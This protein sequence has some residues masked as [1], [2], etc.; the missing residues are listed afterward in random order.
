MADCPDP[1][2]VAR[3]GHERR[4]HFAHRHAETK[5][6]SKEVFLRET[7]EMIAQW[8][9]GFT[10]MNL[11]LRV[12]GATAE[13][14][15]T[16]QKSGKQLH[17][18]L[19]YDPSY[20]PGFNQL[21]SN[22]RQFLLGHT[23]GLLLPR[24]PHKSI[25]GAWWCASPRLVSTLVTYTGHALA[26]NPQEQLV[27]T[28]VNASYARR[29]GV[30]ASSRTIAENICLVEPFST[31]K[32]TEDGIV[33]PALERFLSA[34]HLEEQRW[35][36]TSTP[37]SPTSASSSTGKPRDALQAEYMRRAAGMTTEERLQLLREMFVL[38]APENARKD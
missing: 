5:H 8:I 4:H 9:G 13:L 11:E 6:V 34:R 15:I 31:C 17:L 33:A 25:D 32:L 7:T 30:I 36:S 26:I 29:L 2:F 10:G 12:D 18:T 37:P 20:D 23:R 21:L 16:S 28:I 14:T 19:T 35:R 24:Q 3:G 22:G 1:R 38:Q 27:G